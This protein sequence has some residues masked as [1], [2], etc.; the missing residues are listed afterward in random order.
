MPKF[1]GGYSVQW[2][3]LKNFRY[4]QALNLALYGFQNKLGV[5]KC[6]YFIIYNSWQWHE[7]FLESND[8]VIIVKTAKH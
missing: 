8:A 2:V 1:M 4:W 5:G 7:C 3:I 6:N